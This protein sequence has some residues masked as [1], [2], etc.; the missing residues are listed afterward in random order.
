MAQKHIKRIHSSN[1]LAEK[2]VG[3][4][5]EPCTLNNVMKPAVG[6]CCI[7]VEYYCQ[8][9]CRD[10]NKS[11]HSKEHILLKDAEVPLDPKWFRI[12]KSQMFCSLHNEMVISYLCKDHNQYICLA[13]IAEDHRKC[14]EVEKINT[15]LNYKPNVEETS[16]NL[17]EL[18][19]NARRI[20][21][22]KEANVKDICNEKQAIELQRLHLINELF[23]NVKRLAEDLKQEL[24]RKS[25]TEIQLI[26]QE[27]KECETLKD[28]VETNK[29]LLETV[30]MYGDT[31]YV[32]VVN[33]NIAR[34]I[35]HLRNNLEEKEEKENIS[36]RFLPNPLIRQFVNLGDIE[37]VHGTNK[38]SLTKAVSMYDFGSDEFRST[39][40]VAT[41][42]SKTVMGVNSFMSCSS[43]A[44]NQKTSAIKILEKGGFQEAKLPLLQRQPPLLVNNY[45]IKHDTD[46]VSCNIV[47]SVFFEDDS[48][49]LLDSA[50]KN[51]KVFS[52]TFQLLCICP[53]PDSPTDICLFNGN[54]VVVTFPES[55]RINRYEITKDKSVIWY[56][57]GFAT[58]L[59]CYSIAPFDDELVAVLCSDVMFGESV[60]SDD[61]TIMIQLRKVHNGQIVREIHEF[62]RIN[63]ETLTLNDPKQIRVTSEKEILIS[64]SNMLHC[65]EFQEGCDSEE[66]KQK[67]FYKNSKM[68]YIDNI[69]GVS[70]DEEG[71]IYVCG[72]TSKNIHQIS[73]YNFRN[74][75]VLVSGIKNPISIAV[76]T[77]KGLI[78]VGCEDKNSISVYPFG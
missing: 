31:S 28:C 6:F 39:N 65:F 60:N 8:N 69:A 73:R 71:N 59:Y 58:S 2:R 3:L 55:K 41:W 7:C 63:G 4:Y 49:A 14:D 21:T 37:V 75:R 25:K 9:C 38:A 57:R 20:L 78:C 51:I 12:I 22:K 10:H 23:A 33:G 52:A 32:K 64:D 72:T 66:L 17:A 61:D 30:L 36:L 54:Y 62:A 77:K 45:H 24:D 5:C 47:T 27:I 76:N 19:K 18:E 40:P 26:E 70:I 29:R 16:R 43:E 46:S 35:E 15:G 68:W 11:K 74:N 13:C 34:N 1:E 44:I 67:W 42:S 50:N 56:D 53:F 48:I